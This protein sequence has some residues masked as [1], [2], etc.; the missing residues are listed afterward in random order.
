[1]IMCRDDTGV[2]REQ[3]VL[4]NTSITLIQLC[5]D[6]GFDLITGPFLGFLT[7]FRLGASILIYIDSIWF[8]VSF[9]LCLR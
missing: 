5:F 3:F 6:L 7:D 1:M 4:S 2:R 9:D 8:R